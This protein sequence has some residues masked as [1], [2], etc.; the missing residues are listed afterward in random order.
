[1]ST[2][3]APPAPTPI[4]GQLSAPECTAC[5][6]PHLAMPTRGPQ[7]TLGSYRV[8]NLIVRVLS[9]GMQGKCLPG[10]TD[11]IGTP[12]MHDTT[13]Y[14][15]LARWADDRALWQA[16]VARV[17]HLAVEKPRDLRVLHGDGT[18]TVAKTGAM[19]WATRATHSSRGRT[20]SPSSPLMATS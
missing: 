15:V 12:A 13:V 10:P 19:G 3:T 20:S 8:L 7:C 4:P 5:L 1:M 11:A 6:V 14:N 17:R 2:A 9:T 18:T 16:L